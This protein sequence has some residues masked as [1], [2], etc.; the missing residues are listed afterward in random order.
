MLFTDYVRSFN[1]FL[2]NFLLGVKQTLPSHRLIK[3]FQYSSILQATFQQ[4]IYFNLL[5]YI[6][7]VLVYNLI[8]NPLIEY[9]N[10]DTEHNR[11]KFI[12]RYIYLFYCMRLIIEFFLYNTLF[13]SCAA[14]LGAIDNIELDKQIEKF[15][16]ENKDFCKCAQATKLKMLLHSPLYD[17]SNQLTVGLV[18]N[19]ISPFM[20]NL[21]RIHVYGRALVGT[22]FSATGFCV[23]HSQ[24]W[25]SQRNFLCFGVG[26]SF[27]CGY[28]LLDILL[29][30]SLEYIRPGFANN[31]NMIESFVL[32]DGMFY[33]SW[34]FYTFTVQANISVLFSKQEYQFNLF[35]FNNILALKMFDILK[36]KIKKIILKKNGQENIMM[37]ILTRYRDSDIY[38]I[39][40]YI[41]PVPFRSFDSFFSVAPLRLFIY[42]N[43]TSFLEFINWMQ[44]RTFGLAK[45]AVK[46]SDLFDGGRVFKGVVNLWLPDTL[47][48]LLFNLITKG[49][50]DNDNI[51][52]LE[53]NVLKAT[54]QIS[55][56]NFLED[57][58]KCFRKLLGIKKN[59]DF[60]LLDDQPV[61]VISWPLSASDLPILVSDDHL[62]SVTSPAFGDFEELPPQ[63]ATTNS[64]FNINGQIIDLADDHFTSERMNSR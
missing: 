51:K 21:M 34:L 50:F 38:N 49:V 9:F 18:S 6:F 54:S 15:N 25:L 56:L 61:P 57:T 58:I 5:R 63:E 33:L 60:E 42:L 12:I 13:A 43:Y 46:L 40:Y 30:S 31:L 37:N 22:H 39:M 1:L 36:P 19:A 55:E 17:L 29:N 10:L 11:V 16:L 8:I 59:H 44:S 45:T 47:I 2:Y 27:I 32:H 23:P 14:N 64:S 4:A 20:G 35:R 53:S 3:K 7:P 28:Y 26:F 48:S 62:S 52:W 24:Q 41:L